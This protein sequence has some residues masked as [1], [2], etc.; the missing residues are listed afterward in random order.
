MWPARL[1]GAP[2]KKIMLAATARR[3]LTHVKSRV[4]R[5]ANP[6]DRSRFVNAPPR[7][8]PGYRSPARGARKA[9]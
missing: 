6:P 4:N 8:T 2:L 5:R 3:V 7:V 1:R 9:L